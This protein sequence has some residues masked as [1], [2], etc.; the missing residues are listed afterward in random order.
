MSDAIAIIATLKNDLNG[1]L[2]YYNKLNYLQWNRK[3]LK[4]YFL[5][6]ANSKDLSDAIA[7]IATLKNDFNGKLWWKSLN[8]ATLIGQSF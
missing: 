8:F 3:Y 1:K 2:W 6:A 4:T 7:I 5:I